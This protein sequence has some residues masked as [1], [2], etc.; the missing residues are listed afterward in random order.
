MEPLFHILER[1]GAWQVDGTDLSG[2]A[3]FKLFFPVG[4]EPQIQGIR[5]AGNFQNALGGVDWDFAGGLALTRTDRV[6]GAFWSVVTAQ[7]LPAHFYEYKYQVTFNNGAVRIVSD[8][9]TRYGASENQNA[10]V[11]VGGS[12]PAQNV[13]TPLAK[14]LPLRDLVIYEMHVDDFTDEYRGLR[15]PLDAVVDKLDYLAVLGF[16]AILFMP[17][18]AWKHRDFDWG[19]E[20]YQY[21]A[22]EYRY[23][24]DLSRPEE[25]LSWLKRLVSACHQRGI[26]VIFDGV[27]NHV[28]YDFPYKDFYFNIND[29]PY[30]GKFEGQFAGLQDLNFNN[31]CTQDFIRDV[32]L[33]WIDT[34]KIDGIRFDNTTNYHRDSDAKGIPQLLQDIQSFIEQRGEANFSMTLEH[35]N[36]SAARIVNDTQATSYWDNALYESCFDGLWN[37]RINPKLLRALNNN[38]H[39]NPPDK[40]ATLYL[41]NHD[42]SHVNWQAGARDNIG[43]FRW[44][45]TQP[46]LIAL[47]TCP[48]APMIQNGQ[49]FGEDHRIPEDDQ[50]TGRRVQ[51][52]PLHWKYLGDSIGKKLSGVYQ[53]LI[54][55]R[56]QHPAL[57]SAN[58]YPAT[59]EEWQTRFNSEGYGIDTEK[60]VIIYHRWGN[61]GQGQLQRFIIVLNFSAD[62][63]HV[64]VPFSANGAWEDLLSGWKP[65]VQNNQLQLQLSAYWGHV[66]LQ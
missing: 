14:R 11:V 53:Q 2:R 37:E 48:G 40:V 51:P 9:Y 34:F 30:T 63:Q 62:I 45:K 18:T 52:R 25:K 59:W 50:G 61:N 27:F 44:Y 13:V 10:A 24:N 42:H 16:N 38:Q 17:W 49:E 35:L 39:V 64:S 1:L 20:P 41:S 36:Q 12:L 60:Q 15:A 65:T 43:A 46:Y 3:Q 32:C 56:K 26:H 28:S 33:Y 66:F 47:L 54:A 57:R 6:E 22:V 4:F 7:P 55:I 5:V 29:C 31:A 21:F 23:A 19:Y 8:P 58:F